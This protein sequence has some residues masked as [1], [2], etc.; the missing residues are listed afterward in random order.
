MNSPPTD[1]Y[2]SRT[3]WLHAL[4]AGLVVLLWLA[5]QF[6]DLWPRGNPRLIVRSLHMSLGLVLGGLIAWRLVRRAR[7]QMRPLP[8]LPG[9][10]GR[11]AAA[12][13]GLLYLAMV[14]AVCAGMACVWVRGD[15]WFGL[16]RFPAFDPENRALRHDVVELHGLLANVLLGLAVGHAAIALWH[17]RVLKDD[18]L[19]RMWPALRRRG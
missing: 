5:G 14:L 18:V 7:G 9:L 1:T 8:A 19:R 16:F 12:G 13:H 6:L 11:S 10:A 3:V 15:S 4:S 2:D 17:H